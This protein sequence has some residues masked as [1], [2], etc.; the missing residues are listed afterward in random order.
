MQCY[1]EQNHIGLNVSYCACGS[2]LN[3]EYVVKLI[4][5]FSMV[6]LLI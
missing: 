4:L 6:L 3:N 2:Q 5:I 1:W